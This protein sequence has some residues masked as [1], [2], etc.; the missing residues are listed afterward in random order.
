MDG[1]VAPLPELARLAQHY[2]AMLY[3]MLAL[4]IVC[5]RMAEERGLL[6][7]VAPAPRAFR[8]G[9]RRAVLQASPRFRRGVPG[10]T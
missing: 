5:R 10:R 7:A 8:V 1:D 3:V 9:A 6:K 2:G 4:S